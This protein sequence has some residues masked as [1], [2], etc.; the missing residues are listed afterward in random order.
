M[1]ARSWRGGSYPN[2]FSFFRHFAVGGDCTRTEHYAVCE[3]LGI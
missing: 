2:G 3:Q 1:I